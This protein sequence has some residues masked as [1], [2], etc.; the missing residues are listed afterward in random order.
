M[1][2]VANRTDPLSRRPDLVAGAAV[3]I[4]DDLLTRI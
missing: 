4:E 3:G 2:G 1:A